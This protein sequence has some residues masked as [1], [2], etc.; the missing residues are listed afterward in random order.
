MMKL[1]N[2]VFF[3]I[4]ALLMSGCATNLSKPSHS[5]EPTTVRLGEFEQVEMKSV[6]ISDGFAAHSAN[7][8]ALKKIDELLFRDMRLLY[9]DLK[10]IEDGE[11]FSSGGARTLQITP[12]IKEIKF[13]GGAARFWVGAMAGSSAVLME[14][15]YRDGANGEV[16]G[17]PEFYRAANA[18][19]GGWTIGSTD[20]QMLENIVEDVI[21]Y[22]R[23]NR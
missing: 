7:Q 13:I 10:R 18:H 17:Q 22:T 19:A 6:S 8:K 23:L 4:S 3:L 16:I 2:Y 1:P 20:N 15:T 21:N 9:P 14:T 12:H 11:A 5:L